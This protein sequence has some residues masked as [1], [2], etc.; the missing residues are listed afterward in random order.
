MEHATRPLLVLHERRD[1]LADQ[2]RLARA[3]ITDDGHELRRLKIDRAP[4][5]IVKR[6]QML[7]PAY[8][9]RPHSARALRI[10]LD[11]HEASM[12]LRDRRRCRCFRARISRGTGRSCRHCGGRYP[13]E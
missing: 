2:A 1:E 6:R 8:E 10:R 4:D 12:T 11:P 3:L 9:R 13:T 5:D 7:R